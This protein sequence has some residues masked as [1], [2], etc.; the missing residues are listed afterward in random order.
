MPCFLIIGL[1]WYFLRYQVYALLILKYLPDYCNRLSR[2]RCSNG[3]Y[4]HVHSS[5]IALF[6]I[7]PFVLHLWISITTQSVIV[8]WGKC[9]KPINF[10]GWS[11]RKQVYHG[12]HQ[13]LSTITDDWLCPVALMYQVDHLMLQLSQLISLTPKLRDL[14]FIFFPN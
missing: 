7:L 12:V 5:E 1:H 10:D 4:Q 11:M 8:V 13:S 14:Y 6:L 3:S 9:N 2:R